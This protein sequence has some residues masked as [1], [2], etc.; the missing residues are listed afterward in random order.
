MIRSFRPSAVWLGLCTW[1]LLAQAQSMAPANTVDVGEIDYPVVITPT[2]LKQSLADVPAS[3][4]IITSD[5]LERYGINTVPDALM[6][7][8]G[9]E[10]MRSGGGRPPF[11]I[12]YHGTNSA[13]PRRMNVLIDGVSVYSAGLSGT[14]WHL[15]PVAIEDIDR[16]EVT[17]GTDSASYGPNSM[18]AVINI[19][20]KHP[21]DVESF[22]LG[23][24]TDNRAPSSVT[25]RLARQ[26]GQ[27]S[28]RATYKLTRDEGYDSSSFKHG[29]RD[30]QYSKHLN[31]RSYTD[32]GAG[33][34]LEGFA[35]LVDTDWQIGQQD[36][37]QVTFPDVKD[38][39]GL[40]AV[41]L[42]LGL[43][44]QHQVQA[45]ASIT[46]AKYR[47]PWQACWP[48]AAFL[49]E[50]QELALS[51]VNSYMA[52]LLQGKLNL[53]SPVLSDDPLVRKA[54]LAVAA[55]GPAALNLH[56]G[57][58][59]HHHDE[60]RLQAEIQDTYVHSPDLRVVAGVGMRHQR[61]TSQTMLSGT[62]SNSVVWAFGHA[63]I[64]PRND[65][66]VNLGGYYEHNNLGSNTFSPR[67]AVN[68]QLS[69]RQ[70]LRAVYSEGTRTPDIVQEKANW[71]YRLYDFSPAINGVTSAPLSKPII[72]LGGGLTERIRSVELG[73]LQQIPALGLTLDVKAFDDH[74]SD[75]IID[76][77][78]AM[79]YARGMP[80]DSSVRLTGLELQMRWALTQ[81]WSGFL[82][83]CN[84]LNRDA[85]N[86]IERDLYSRHSGSL[87]ISR[88]FGDGWQTSLAFYGA[89][90]DGNLRN[91]YSRT[92]LHLSRDFRLGG[93]RTNAALTLSYLDTPTVQD[94]ATLIGDFQFGYKR[95][96]GIGGSIRISF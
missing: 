86:A 70:T 48:R 72:S 77:I 1:A 65:V 66:S 39:R 83:Y 18:M 90:A 67:V 58:G 23:A 13:N 32:L 44:P 43:T 46:T 76:Y 19:Q 85:I 75:L 81:G 94:F 79:S 57:T 35:A 47:Q 36:A 3:V 33:T 45:N 2:R 17:R 50:V 14:E 95:Q 38:E 78:S 9:M 91:R 93:Y 49:P 22:Y 89:S 26:W 96:L 21:K 24:K 4:T 8:P 6:L 51:G 84:L 27:T 87:G 73:Y 16:I 88:D 15:L 52:D 74:L 7:V 30:T 20:T 34:A 29:A 68:W 25:T 69:D 42:T 59:D 56:C 54:M 71:T 92:D 5:M 37:Y 60:S 31:V 11:K 62:A 10:S 61:V 63:E 12:S 82:N 53:L 28:L 64:R 80:S 41:R 40:A 55:L